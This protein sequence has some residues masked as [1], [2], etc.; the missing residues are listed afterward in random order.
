VVRF[1]ETRSYL[2]LKGNFRF[3]SKVVRFKGESGR[4]DVQEV[5][6]VSI[7]KWCDSKKPVKVSTS[8]GLPSFNSKV[9]RFK[10]TLGNNDM[11]DYVV[12]IPKWC[13]S[14]LLKHPLFFDRA[15]FQ[16]QSGAIQRNGWLVETKV[17][18]GSFNS[19]VVRFKDLEITDEGQAEL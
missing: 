12:S 17:H 18:K 3:N 10:A 4:R 19:K 8:T 13:D 16:F 15:V 7:P 9:V 6:D 2:T 14:K 1:K 5:F 11:P